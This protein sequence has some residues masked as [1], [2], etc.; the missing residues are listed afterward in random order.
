VRRHSPRGTTDLEGKITTILFY[1]ANERPYGVFSNLFRRPIVFEGLEFATAEHAYQTGKARKPAVAQWIR[2][3]PTGAL[4]AM[5]GHELYYW[6]VV[7]DWSRIKYQRMRDVLKAKF[8]QHGDLRA[9]L[10]STGDARLVEAG[11]VATPVNLEWGEV[12]GR[13]RNKLG[14]L[15]MELRTELAL[16]AGAPLIARANMVSTSRIA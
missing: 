5:A 14:I 8:T 1:R 16:E 12:N 13:G 15:L 7:P 6:D 10:I 9:I 2:A 4:A 11:R 3:A